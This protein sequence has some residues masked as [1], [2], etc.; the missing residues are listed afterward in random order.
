MGLFTPKSKKDVAMDLATATLAKA[1]VKKALTVAA[2]TV[3][4]FVT[5]TAA[6]AAISSARHQDQS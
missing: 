6:S 3:A 4:G 2:S 1:G 5:L